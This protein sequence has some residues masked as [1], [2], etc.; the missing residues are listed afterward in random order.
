[1][2]VKY[3]KPKGRRI[4][5]GS[6]KM[7]VNGVP[8][9]IDNFMGLEVRVPNLYWW[10]KGNMWINKENNK[11]KVNG[12]LSTWNGNIKNLKQAIR[13]IKKHNEIPKGTKF[14]LRSRF[15]GYDII[16]IK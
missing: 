4:K 5:K 11:F 1:M 12:W 8:K 3:I 7:I 10:N 14:I 13:Y 9:R 16:I 6:I 15:K 2:K